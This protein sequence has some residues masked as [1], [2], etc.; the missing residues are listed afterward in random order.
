MPAYI[1]HETQLV[2]EEFLAAVLR[3]HEYKARILPE[4]VIVIVHT[5]AFVHGCGMIQPSALGREA[6]I[7]HGTARVMAILAAAIF[8]AIKKKHSSKL[9]DRVPQRRVCGGIGT[10]FT[11][12]V[13]LAQVA[14]VRW[15]RSWSGGRP[16]RGLPRLRQGGAIQRHFRHGQGRY[17]PV[18]TR[19]LHVTFRH[20]AV[21]PTAVKLNFQVRE[22]GSE[23]GCN[24]FKGSAEPAHHVFKE[25]LGSINWR[26]PHC[27]V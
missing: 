17:F 10:P 19:V 8:G 11:V 24:R 12:V 3:R 1:L 25:V 26:I 20:E 14:L 27:W 5:R 21:V 4:G 6:V 13:P 18:K 23:F 16:R 15:L 9:S 2:L 7:H 22:I